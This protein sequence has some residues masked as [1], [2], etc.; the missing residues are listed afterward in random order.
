MVV[1]KNFVPTEMYKYMHTF[2]AVEQKAQEGRAQHTFTLGVSLA[3]ALTILHKEK[4]G[5]PRQGDA[6]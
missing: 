2:A 1:L 4:S 5:L 3:S 6:H